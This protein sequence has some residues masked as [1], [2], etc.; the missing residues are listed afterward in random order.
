MPS[1]M[2]MIT[3]RRDKNAISFF[4][5]KDGTKMRFAIGKYEK[6]TWPELVDIKI[7]DWCDVG[8]NFCYQDS[9]IFGKH[10]SMENMRQVIDRLSAVKV[11]EIACLEEN[12]LVATPSGMRK[13]IDLEI[14]DSIFDSNGRVSKIKKKKVSHRET[15]TIKGNRGFEVTST[16]D[17]PFMVNGVETRADDLLGEVLDNGCIVDNESD[18]EVVDMSE[19]ITTRNE[20]NR[21]SRSGSFDDNWVKMGSSS[22]R[23]KRFVTIDEDVAWLYGLVVAEG[24]SRGITL[25]STEMNYAQRTVEIYKRISGYSSRIYV[26]SN[27]IVVEF[28]CPSWY[29]NLFFDHMKINHLAKNKS[30]GYLFGKNKSIVRSGIRGYLDGDG[31]FRAKKSHGGKY[32][33]YSASFK[34]VSPYIATELTTLLK[35]VFGADACAYYGMSPDRKI[36]GRIIKSSPYYKI[37]IYGKENLILVFGEDEMLEVYSGDDNFV[38]IGTKKTGMNTRKKGIKVFSIENS[39]VKRVVDIQLDNGS[40]HIFQISHGVLS[41]NCGGG[42][43]TGHPHFVEI[44]KMAYEAGIVPNFTTKKPA[45]VRK[46]WPEI[47]DYV[48][49]FAYSAENAGQV[50][51]AARTFKGHIPD[52]KVSLHYVMGLG[53]RDHF[54]DYL[55]AANEVGYRVTLLG[56]KTVGRGKDVIPFPYDW[57]VDVV[58]D[59]VKTGECPTLSIDTP[60]AEQYDGKMPVPTFMYHTR[61]G[62]FSMYIDAVSMEMGAS[63]FDQKPSLVPF[64]EDW[65]ARYAII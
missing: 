53:D 18:Y 7:T 28:H 36:E 44:V 57:W 62:A 61:E 59:L 27:R 40:S 2:P 34:T 3:V 35:T 15:I 48:G 46:M 31:C 12:T 20:N 29:K 49:G 63:S 13:I 51:M 32:T 26:H 37:D 65:V 30:L 6:A 42:E 54:V 38:S 17:H 50:R 11:Q 4:S 8:C 21:F 41:H 64:D 52:Q 1:K 55:K 5:R 24:S 33:D 10:A 56:Y 22:K 16:P 45:V 25:N 19:Y 58:S 43:T 47:K 39:G 9:T 60:L 14:N 23:G